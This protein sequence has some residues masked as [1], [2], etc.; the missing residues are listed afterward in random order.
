MARVSP[1]KAPVQA[2]L[3]PDELRRG[4]NRL[5]KRLEE[6]R[7]FNPEEME[8]DDPHPL[9]RPLSAAIEASLAE[10]F[11]VDTVEYDR[12]HRASYFNYSINMMQRTP[13][14]TIINDLKRERQKSLDLLTAAINL[15]ND[16]LNEG[17]GDGPADTA[18]PSKVID[19]KKVFIVHGHDEA[20]RETVARFVGQ[21]GMTP[22]I[23]HEQPNK[24]RTIIS[25]FR[26][27]AASVGFAIVL[28][29]PDDGELPRQN[30]IFELGFFL[31]ALGAERVAAIVKQP[32]TTPSDYDGV[33]YIPY[34]GS[35]GWKIALAKEMKAAGYTIDWNAVMGGG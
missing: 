28:V 1:P 15:M 5:T 29:T 14:G 35:G 22:V 27:E 32:V 3:S 26:D 31:G 10:T 33:V 12:Y 19:P 23:L 25:K 21:I 34:D 20:I 2:R 11:G 17:G 9:T 18:W 13:R 6:V 24:G 4:I 30:V 16:R 7:A 8:G